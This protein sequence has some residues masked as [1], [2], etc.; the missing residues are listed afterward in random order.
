MHWENKLLQ[1]C[2]FFLKPTKVYGGSWP[3]KSNDG[4][5]E[6]SHIAILEK[7]QTNEL[8]EKS[9]EFVLGVVGIGRSAVEFQFHR[10]K[11]RY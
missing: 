9:L 1:Q 4:F 5:E 6:E 8:A 3:K 10:W 2:H 11:A 7:N